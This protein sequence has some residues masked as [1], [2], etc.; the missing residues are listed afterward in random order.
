MACNELRDL[1]RLLIESWNRGDASAF[2]GLFTPDAEYVTGTGARVRGRQA[3]AALVQQTPRPLV[4]LVGEPEVGCDSR[5][6][7]LRFAWSAVQGPGAARHGRISC[8]C[9]RH[10]FGWLL[11]ALQNVEDGSVA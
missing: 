11:D 5:K 6:G 1:A 3:I 9:I 4:C 2:A 7:Q 10:E 8:A